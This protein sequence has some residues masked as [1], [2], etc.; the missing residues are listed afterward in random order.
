MMDQEIRFDG[1][2]YW[3]ITFHGRGKPLCSCQA[4]VQLIAATTT[5]TA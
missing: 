2:A 1:A 3:F 5:D 4:V